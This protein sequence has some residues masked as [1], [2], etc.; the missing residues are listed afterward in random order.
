MAF[1]RSLCHGERGMTADAVAWLSDW[2]IRRIQ[3]SPPPLSL[4]FLALI[5]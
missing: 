5:R 4:S 3:L 1:S 2:L